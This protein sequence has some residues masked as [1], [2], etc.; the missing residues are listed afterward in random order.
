MIYKFIVKN[1]NKKKRR[2]K[3]E[4]KLDFLSS[5]RYIKL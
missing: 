1:E 4:K 2:K 3:Y 5:R